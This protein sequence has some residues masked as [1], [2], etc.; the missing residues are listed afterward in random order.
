MILVKQRTARSKGSS[1][2]MDCLESLQQSFPEAYLTKQ[3][4]FQLMYDIQDD[5]AL[6]VWEC[7]RWKAISWN[8]LV[9]FYDKLRKVKPEGY[10]CD[11]LFQ[12][13]R[14][15]CLVFDGIA[16]V[17]FE[18]AYHNQ[19]KKHEPVKRCKLK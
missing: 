17:T 19:F 16:I 15:P 4:G 12:S 13:N 8:Q 6:R 18:T 1:Y 7:K 14:Q 2:E 10:N 5:K 9:K 3:K 11:V